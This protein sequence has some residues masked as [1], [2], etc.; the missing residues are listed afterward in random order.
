[1]DE[2]QLKR[3]LVDTFNIGFGYPEYQPWTINDLECRLEAI[4]EL[5]SPRNRTLTTTDAIVKDLASAHNIPLPTT[6]TTTNIHQ[7][8][9]EKAAIAFQKGKT[10]FSNSSN[11]QYLWS[12]GGCRWLDST[13]TA[14]K[15]R[16]HDD[17]LTFEYR[18]G[19]MSGRCS[20]IITCL[21]T[22]T[23]KDTC[24]TLS[25]NSA[26]NGRI[27]R[28]PI[29]CYSTSQNFTMDVQKNFVI[30]LDNLIKSIAKERRNVSQ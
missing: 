17:I 12:D 25:I 1:M 27:I 5:L 22:L 21:A 18:D 23:D 7:D 20:I 9:F 16:R 15:E 26:V 13:Q 8:I 28:I 30:E 11:D 2:S 4:R 14:M 24:I 29:G 6:S 3:Y 19:R 10:N